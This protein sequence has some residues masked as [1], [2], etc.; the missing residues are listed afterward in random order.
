LKT[1]DFHQPVLVDEVLALLN[2]KSG[3]KYIDATLGGA[4]HT[5]EII[6]RG[7][8]VLGIDADYDA[9]DYVTKN[10]SEEISAKKLIVKQGNFRNITNL[11]AKVGFEKV[12][13]IIFDLGTSFYQLKSATKGFGFESQTLDMRM[14]SNLAVSAYD[15]INN[16][17]K[18]RLYEA[19]KKYGQERFAWKI[20]DAIDSARKIKPIKSAK[21]LADLI[22]MTKP[23]TK[24]RIH[25]ATQTFL[26]LRIVVNSELE[27][28]KFAL[29]Q[30][31]DLLEPK[32]RIGVISFHSLEDKIVKEIFKEH[33]DL[34]V[35]TKKPVGPAEK[36]VLLNPRARSAKLRIAEITH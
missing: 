10:F 2:I 6:K 5:R 13:G 19:I 22:S 23:K 33:E 17:D 15:L 12:A 4:G 36:E 8:I 25:P 29:P 20:V 7:G 14:D 18:R 11:A 9:I 1:F 16:L 32:A 34:R 27:N 24:K 30:A 35:I 28:L 21:E 3:K 31:I 26:A